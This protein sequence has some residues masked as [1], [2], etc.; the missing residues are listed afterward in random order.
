MKDMLNRICD[1]VI[2]NFKKAKEEFRFD[3]EYINHFASLIYANRNEEIPTK[4]IKEIRTYIKNNTS[5]MS[6]FRGDILYILSILIGN[7]PNVENFISEIIDTYEN[8]IEY[9]FKESQYLVLTAYTIVKHSKR[10][11]REEIICKTKDVYELMKERYDNVTNEED[12]LGC[13][14]LA[15][16]KVSGRNLNESMSNVFETVSELD[17]F[18]KNSVQGLAMALSLNKKTKHLN[19]VRDLLV[20]F[21]ENDMKISHQFLP[22]LGVTSIN[23]NIQDYINEVN[24]VI[25]YLSEEDSQYEFYMDK[26]FRTFIAIALIEFSKDIKEERYLEELLSMGVYSFLVS[27]N[28][29]LF[30]EIL[31]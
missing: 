8:L 9:G 29:G 13:C 28:Q 6:Y 7:E 1:I 16:N 2:S 15:L 18:S 23:K 3:G 20:E 19:R 30:S 17:M 5:R 26:S 25:E 11:E 31:A 14:L 22:L 4:E 21:E 12:H 10:D 27:K 24:E